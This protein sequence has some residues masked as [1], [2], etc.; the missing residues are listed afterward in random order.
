MEERNKYKIII[1]EEASDEIS[2]LHEYYEERSLGLGD[3]F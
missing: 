2:D 1:V 3:I